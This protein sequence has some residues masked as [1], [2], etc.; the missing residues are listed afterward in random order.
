MA[1]N[2]KNVLKSGVGTVEST[3]LT[4][5][6][7]AKTTILGLSLSNL[8]SGIVL[9]NIKLTDPTGN[10]GSPVTAY[11]VKE[12]IIPPNQS[13]RIVNG[14]EKLVLGPSTTI[15]MSAN[16]DDS[17]DLVMSYVEIV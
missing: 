5:G 16:F 1:T 17:L 11:F 2:F 7:N 10:A 13:L 3:I 9:A 8:T 15:K 6:A 14:G 12:I 4:T